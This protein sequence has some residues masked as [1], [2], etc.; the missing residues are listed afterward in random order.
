MDPYVFYIAL[1]V[2]AGI[3]TYVLLTGPV[4]ENGYKRKVLYA[5]KTVEAIWITWSPGAKSKPHDH[6]ISTGKIWVA[7]GQIFQKIFDKKTKEM[8]N[9][10][11]Y[12]AGET[13]E[14]T[15]DIIHIMG[16]PSQ[17]EEAETLH[18]YSP[19][20]KMTDYELAE[21]KFP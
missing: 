18:V 20:L 6:G 21:L 13:L 11:M 15:P 12:S 1:G 5:N 3:V 17:T 9:L 8:K 4:S 2:L 10:L 14:E 7:K 16:N 19:P